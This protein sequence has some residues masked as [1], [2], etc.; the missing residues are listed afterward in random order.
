[1]TQ[2]EDLVCIDA[3]DRPKHAIVWLHGLGADGYDFVPIA[4]ELKQLG[5]PPTRFLF[6]HAPKIPVSINGGYIMR[7]WYDI[8]YTE[9][10][11]EEDE[12]GIRLS[13]SRVDRMIDQLIAEGFQPS[14]IVIAGF[15]Q[16]GAIAYQTALRSKHK[17]GGL[18]CLSTYLTC[19]DSFSDERTP[20]NQ[21]I[22]ILVCH[23]IADN[24]VLPE[25]G[26]KAAKLLA[27][28]GYNVSWKA[29]NMPHSVCAEEIK[30]IA[31][32]LKILFKNTAL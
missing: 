10:Q 3:G 15:S 28:C 24:V 8:K 1:M 18:I 6:P 9:L 17:L 20:H 5:L 12:A 21:E 31:D 7:A 27:E 29:Y 16:G 4:E 22:P 11:R 19:V 14:N 26:Q 23:G 13:Q 25:R 2:Q 32:F 30:D